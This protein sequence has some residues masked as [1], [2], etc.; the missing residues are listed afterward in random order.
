MLRC[1][2]FFA[3]VYIYRFCL[4]VLGVCSCVVFVA[5]FALL[6]SL[7]LFVSLFLFDAYRVA[8]CVVRVAVLSSL[9]C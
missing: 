8:V 4:F 2:F 1:F 9:V 5:R 7:C 6:L 3:A